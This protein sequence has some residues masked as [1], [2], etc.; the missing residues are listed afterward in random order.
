MKEL[1]KSNLSSSQRMLLALKEARSQLEVMELAKSEPIAIV[2]IG[3]RFP[4]AETPG[5]FWQLL[6][7]GVDVVTEVPSERWDVDSYYSPDL[8]APGK[9][10]TRYGSF[11]AS[12]DRFDPAFFGISPR[13]AAAMD[14]QQRLLLEVSWEAL[15]RAGWVPER[16]AGSKTGV[17]V[18]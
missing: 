5:E 9:T 6:K 7:K 12:V 2:G 14:P 17:F 4:R 11:V 15:E 1:A 13:E 18:G 3:C 16:K 10:Y 8:D